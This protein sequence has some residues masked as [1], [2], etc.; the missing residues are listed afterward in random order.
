M[1]T[2]QSQPTQQRLLV[3]DDDPVSLMLVQNTLNVVG[4]T[5]VITVDHGRAI[6]DQIKAKQPDLVI[7]DIMMPEISGIDVLATIRKQYT[8]LELPVIMYTA[9][10]AADMVSQALSGGANDYIVK[11]LNPVVVQARIETQLRLKHLSAE[12]ARRKRDEAIGAMVV[13]YNHEINNALTVATISMQN[14]WTKRNRDA[15]MHGEAA[16][17][18]IA[19][20][21]R[22]IRQAPEREHETVTYCG[23][24]SMVKI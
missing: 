16:L 14:A 12:L 4:Y 15:F 2:S 17:Q 3:I 11:P 22:K 18:R 5:D 8:A 21:L 19:D 9:C 13:T 1:E 23:K 10:E 24:T 6:L 7:L 20:I